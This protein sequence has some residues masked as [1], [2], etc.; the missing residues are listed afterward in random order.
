MRRKELLE[1]IRQAQIPDDAYSLEGGHPNEAFV[2]SR[3][4]SSWSV[5]Y[6]ERGLE[7]SKRTFATEAEAC[8]ELWHLLLQYARDAVEPND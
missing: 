6:S 2:L 7:T 5:Y 3:E 8:D 4:G 1:A